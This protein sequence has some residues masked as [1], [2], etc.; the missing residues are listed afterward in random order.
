[1]FT[2]RLFKIGEKYRNTYSTQKRMVIVNSKTDFID[3]QNHTVKTSH[4]SQIPLYN[5][6]LSI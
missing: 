1:M 5:F 4:T 6:K 2:G 3:G